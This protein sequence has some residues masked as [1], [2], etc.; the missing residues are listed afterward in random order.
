MGG[1]S[2][3]AAFIKAN[4]PYGAGGTLSLQQAW[5][6]AAFVVSRPRPQDPRF[7]GNVEQTRKQFH[8]KNSYYGRVVNGRLLGAPDKPKD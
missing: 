8:P 5:D 6:V 1:I 4:M 2:T 3:A 7:T